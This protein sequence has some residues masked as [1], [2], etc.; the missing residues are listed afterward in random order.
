MT[1]FRIEGKCPHCERS[2]NFKAEVEPPP[3][4][5]PPQLDHEDLTGLNGYT[6]AL[7]RVIRAERDRLGYSARE[8]SDIAGCS[9]SNLLRIESGQNTTNGM[10]WWIAEALDCSLAILHELAEK[11]LNSQQEA[12]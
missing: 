11:D 3:R 10:L 9:E 5:E 1:L 7:G 4:T 6:K 12:T 8:L 2:I